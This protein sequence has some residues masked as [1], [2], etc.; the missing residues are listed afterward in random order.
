VER[1]DYRKERGRKRDVANGIHHLETYLIY[2]ALKMEV[3]RSLEMSDS[4][5]YSVVTHSTIIK[6]HAVTFRNPEY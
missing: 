1:T 3:A 2:S 4:A 6:S 5:S